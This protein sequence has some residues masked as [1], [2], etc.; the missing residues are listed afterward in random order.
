LAQ[1][2]FRLPKIEHG[3][4]QL[5]G[6]EDSGERRVHGDQETVPLKSPRQS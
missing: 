6:G 2:D 3:D 1:G 5:S 4:A